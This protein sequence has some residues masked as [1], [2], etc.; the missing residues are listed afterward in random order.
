[1]QEKWE[2]IILSLPIFVSTK[3]ITNEQRINNPR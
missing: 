1:M 2:E 3:D